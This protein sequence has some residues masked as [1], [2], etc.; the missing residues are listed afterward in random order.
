MLLKTALPKTMLPKTM[1]LQM[2]TSSCE[3]RGFKGVVCLRY[4]GVFSHF[5]IYTPDG[6]HPLL[7]MG[8]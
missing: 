7:T 1:L 4:E 6:A 8:P 5:Q 2:M 3:F